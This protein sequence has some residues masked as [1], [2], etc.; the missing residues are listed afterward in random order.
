MTAARPTGA[1]YWSALVL[2]GVIGGLLSGLFGVGGGIVMVP[3]LISLVRMDQR[4][5]ATTSLAAIVPT[6]I[7][8]SLTYQANGHIDLIAGAIIAAGAV[9]GALIGSNLLQR[10]PLFW[11][12]WLFIALLIVVAARMLVV[13]PERGAALELSW[14]VVLG[15]LALGLTMGIASGL[16]GIGGGVIAVPAL[17]AVFGVS[18]LI[19]KGTSLLVLVPT[20]LVGTIANLRA[21]LVDLPAGLVVGAAATV[22]A[23]PGVALAVLIPPRLSSILFAVL[24]ILAAGQLTVKALR[25]K[26][27]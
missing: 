2:T 18:D 27:A 23:V 7:V 15:Y 6:S 24:L 16:F 21:G 20:S 9:V 10:I 8:G 17:V 5:A 13:E 22:A 25:T 12:R 3:L 19:A 4:R 11:L 1:W 14:V 26:R